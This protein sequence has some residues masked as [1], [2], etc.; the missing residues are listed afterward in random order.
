VPDGSLTVYDENVYFSACIF[1]IPAH[2]SG[3]V[4]HD[5]ELDGAFEYTDNRGLQ[6]SGDTFQLGN[7]KDGDRVLVLLIKRSDP[8]LDLGAP[9]FIGKNQ[10]ADLC[11]RIGD[12]VMLAVLVK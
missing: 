11:L 4:H 3:P 2:I 8:S 1:I 6:P 10:H 5:R 12:L 7:T 9:P